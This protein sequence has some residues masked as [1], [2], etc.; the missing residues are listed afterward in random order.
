MNSFLVVAAA[1]SLTCPFLRADAGFSFHDKPGESLDILLDGKIAARYMDAWDDS[2]KQRRLETFKPYLHVYDADGVGP[3]TK[4]AEG[5][6]AQY[7]H[8]RG[9]FIGW[10]K[11]GFNGQVYNLWEPSKCE[12]IHEKFLEE[13][14]D[15]DHATF[16]SATRWND[17]GG[18]IIL[19]EE[20]TMTIRRG[21]APVRLVIDFTSKL[22]AP[23]GDA[24][25]QADPEHGG[26]QFRPSL[27]VDKSKTTYFFPG[28]HPNVHKDVDFPW[29][30]ESFT[31]DE[32]SANPLRGK[33]Y[34]VV[35][36]SHPDDP[37][38]TKWSAYRDYGRFGAYPSATIKKGDSLTL[39]YRFLIADGALPPVEVIEKAYDEF[40]GATAATPAP[41][42]TERP[43][44]G[45][46]AP[47]KR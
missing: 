40:T 47:A 16:I 18:E 11:L 45:A 46:Q 34:S 7:T 13:T 9:I 42:I 37:K 2:T 36:M 12:I 25:L 15:A 5:T 22:T 3:I 43:A 28:E 17:T 30:A 19:T 29:V 32:T 31:I 38:G 10:K 4:G 35:E 39:K 41:R 14:A 33:Q 1:L 6:G 27:D 24:D 20:R 23:N 44:E 26:V 21:P 8:H